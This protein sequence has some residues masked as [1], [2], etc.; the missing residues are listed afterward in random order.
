MPGTLY[1]VATPIGNLDDVSDRA[2]RVL[3]EVD[4]I[5]AEDTR[6]TARLLAR[7]DIRTSVLSYHAHNEA[8][9][10]ARL[11]ARL[12][13]GESVALVSDAGT[14]TI[15]DPGAR[16]VTAAHGAGV[17]VV[18][19]PGPSAIAAALSAS[20]FPAERF[21]FMGFP[22]A[23]GSARRRWFEQLRDEA[24]VVVFF[25]APHRIRKT[26]EALKNYGN[27]PIMVARELTKTH[28]SLVFSPNMEGL[29]EPPERGEF[30]VVLGPS[31]KKPIEIDEERVC[32]MFGLLTENGDFSR[33]K[34]TALVAGAFGIPERDVK[35]LVK[36]ARMLGN[37]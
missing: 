36:K 30:T 20:G 14:P 3:A 2:R 34:A 13:A 21:V 1:V 26:L 10:A 27:R 28:E 11:L 7:F 12:E 35:K 37:R 24:R 5:A 33:E 32:A 6:R 16:L 22:P 29:D 15:A 25:E 19:V 9:R 17:P 4:V 23:A 18:T 31:L 8:A